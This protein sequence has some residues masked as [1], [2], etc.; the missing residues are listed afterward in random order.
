MLAIEMA[1]GQL[2]GGYVGYWHFCPLFRGVEYLN[3]YIKCFAQLTYLVRI[4][5]VLLYLV[6]SLRPKAPWAKC[7]KPWATAS[8]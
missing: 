6:Y 8:K 4:S 5:W 7:R 1:L 3:F 2:S